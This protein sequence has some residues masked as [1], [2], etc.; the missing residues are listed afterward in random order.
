M[1]TFDVLA[2]R[3]AFDN[4][5]FLNGLKAAGTAAQQFVANLNRSLR[6]AQGA[7]D[8]V[9]RSITSLKAAANGSSLFNGLG[10]S[11][12]KA[13]KAAH[14]LSEA[15]DGT[16]R[17]LHGVKTA[18][19]DLGKSTSASSTL[20]QLEEKANGASRAVAALKRHIDG[21]TAAS[22][23]MAPPKLPG[24]ES[25]AKPKGHAKSESEHKDKSEGGASRLAGDLERSERALDKAAKAF[26]L[27]EKM[28]DRGAKWL[29]SAAESIQ[30]STKVQQA[31]AGVGL[32][33]AGTSERFEQLGGFLERFSGASETVATV[34]EWMRTAVE[35]VGPVVLSLATAFTT[36]GGAAVV[37]EAA[38]SPLLTVLLPAAA[39]IAAVVAAIGTL[40]AA[41][42]FVV[43]SV[44]K[45]I[46]SSDAAKAS[47]EAITATFERVRAKIKQFISDC[48]DILYG[49]WKKHE[50]QIERIQIKVG[51]LAL[52]VGEKLAG[53][54]ESV[55]DAVLPVLTAG[56]K[57]LGPVIDFV[58]DAF[59]AFVD[60]LGGDWK[61]A[62]VMGN[63]MVI[64]MNKALITLLE[65]LA[66]VMD[67]N[68]MAIATGGAS[69]LAAKG[70]RELVQTLELENSLRTLANVGLENGIAEDDKKRKQERERKR[71]AKKFDDDIWKPGKAIVSAAIG[72]AKSAI[73]NLP[74]TIVESSGVAAKALNKGTDKALGFLSS[75]IGRGKNVDKEAIKEQEE[76]KT[77]Y[78]LQ[79]SG[80]VGQADRKVAKAAE[81]D[82]NNVDFTGGAVRESHERLSPSEAAKKAEKDR[83]KAFEDA[84]AESKK[85]A[86]NRVALFMPIS[87]GEVEDRQKTLETEL[88]SWGISQKQANL[89]LADDIRANKVADKKALQGLARRTRGQ[90]GGR[91]DY[92]LV[93]EQFKKAAQL[94]I[95]AMK[96]QISSVA[97]CS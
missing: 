79:N 18:A 31:L 82:G 60:L 3:L 9:T 52:T 23:R 93:A 33:A 11:A 15:L 55:T 86:E 95:A 16:K 25:H 74:Q 24:L 8:G 48:L 66:K 38:I 29:R 10:L 43:D 62:M 84:E 19:S 78:K 96:E 37:F 6:T 85:A 13:E 40:T 77:E 35:L 89:N 14:G 2:G 92:A 72:Q 97:K 51:E 44:K 22:K 28:T 36:A 50:E 30:Q 49:W 70:A 58:I 81:A 94:Q 90:E 69:K 57:A 26:T 1:A 75:M 71:I 59:E 63:N 73:E 7:I 76:A 56:L 17:R 32:S 53:A 83:K 21:V 67:S 20:K 88:P 65:S 91:Q 12:S 42:A 54:F 34:V 39:V 5:G 68:A 46:E 47:W 45:A 61:R 87:K 64:N 80:Q 27:V 4:T 41:I